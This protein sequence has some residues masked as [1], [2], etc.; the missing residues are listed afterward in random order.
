[1]KT[2]GNTATAFRPE[3]RRSLDGYLKSL[4]TVPLADAPILRGASG[5]RLTRY[6]FGRLARELMR[7][8]GLPDTLQLRDLRRTASKERTEGGATEAELASATGH[9]IEHG[10]KILDVYNPRSYE[11]AKSAQR[12]RRRRR[13]PNEKRSKV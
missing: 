6:H 8:A 4:G 9:S 10:S 12:K 5:K 7:E 2:A 3:T 1:M 11:L 13:Q